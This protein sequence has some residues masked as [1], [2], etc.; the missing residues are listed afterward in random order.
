MSFNLAELLDD[1]NARI[2]QYGDQKSPYSLILD[3]SIRLSKIDPFSL[4][5][6]NEEKYRQCLDLLVN[7]VQYDQDCYDNLKKSSFIYPSKRYLLS[8]SVYSDGNKKII[9]EN[10]L[11]DFNTFA[12]ELTK[13]FGELFVETLKKDLFLSGGALYSLITQLCYHKLSK[14]VS[15]AIKDYDYYFSSKDTAKEFVELIL[16]KFSSYDGK[17]PSVSKT[18]LGLSMDGISNGFCEGTF[19]LGSDIYSGGVSHNAVTIHRIG[20]PSIQFIISIIGDPE[21]VVSK[22]DFLHSAHYFLMK[23]QTFGI[24][25]FGIRSTKTEK[26]AYN[27]DCQ[28]PLGALFRMKYYL[29]KGFDISRLEML[30]LVM[31]VSKLDFSNKEVILSGLTGIYVDRALIGLEK[32]K[33][34]EKL[35]LDQVLDIASVIDFNEEE[36]ND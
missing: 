26:L 22:F 5:P 12:K 29:S 4:S 35:T 17:K 30:K 21:T 14:K 25:K 1:W 31:S 34:V 27:P 7:H 33:D 13:E 15:L 20:A 36:S 24:N 18:D 19:K 3:G 2:N 16:T 28:R 6:Q 23:D 9:S 8:P 10:I 32:Y 11:G